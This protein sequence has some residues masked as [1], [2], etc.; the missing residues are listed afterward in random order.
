MNEPSIVY[1]KPYYV[2]LFLT[3]CYFWIFPISAITS[4]VYYKK[5]S[6]SSKNANRKF[7]SFLCRCLQPRILRPIVVLSLG[8]IQLSPEKQA[9]VQMNSCLISRCMFVCW[10]I[11]VIHMIDFYKRIKDQPSN[12]ITEVCTFFSGGQLLSIDINE[13]SCKYRLMWK[14]QYC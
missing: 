13:L 14:E 11:Q 6:S 2:A 9:D 10:K 4:N 5:L 8:W 12:T 1:E 7:S 3:F